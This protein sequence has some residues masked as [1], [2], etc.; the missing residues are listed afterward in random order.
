M[1]RKK[2]QDFCDQAPNGLLLL[3][4]PLHLWNLLC[5]L[6]LPMLLVPCDSRGLDEMRER[7]SPTVIMGYVNTATEMGTLL[8]NSKSPLPLLQANT[9]ITARSAVVLFVMCVC[10]ARTVARS[11]AVLSGCPSI[12]YVHTGTAS[13]CVC[14][15]RVQ[16]DNVES[17]VNEFNF[18]AKRKA[19]ATFAAYR[20]AKTGQKELMVVNAA[21]LR[22]IDW[23]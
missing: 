13:S 20:Y 12:V 5:P 17:T 9:I 7:Y 19:A 21:D 18:Q 11:V 16:V 4:A 22:R 2:Y 8:I 15:A 14:V 1:R 3:L 23:F 10:F 6:P